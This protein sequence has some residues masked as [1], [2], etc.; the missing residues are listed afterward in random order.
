MSYSAH[1]MRMYRLP[2]QIARCEEKL[3][4]LKAEYHGVKAE[5]L[6]PQLKTF[7][8]AWEQAVIAAKKEARERGCEDSMGVDHA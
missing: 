6:L 8:T 7:D 5:H 3:A 1:D 2:D 4:R